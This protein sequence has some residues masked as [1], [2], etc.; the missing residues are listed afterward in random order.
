MT[1]DELRDLCMDVAKAMKI[2][3]ANGMIVMEGDEYHWTELETG[4]GMDAVLGWLDERKVAVSLQNV[5][6]LDT[7]ACNISRHMGDTIGK[8]YYGK[9]RHIAVLLAAREVARAEGLL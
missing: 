3:R 4:A 7:W 2:A 8:T 1:T 6:M 5:P 9:S